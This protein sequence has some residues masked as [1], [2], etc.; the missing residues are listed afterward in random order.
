MKKKPT[1]VEIWKAIPGWEGF[2]EVSDLGRVRSIE[3]LARVNSVNP[4]RKRRMG[5]QVRKLTPGTNGYLFVVLT[6]LGRRERWGAHQ[7]VLAA[8]IGPR[9]TGLV[10]RHLDGNNINN[11]PRN[12]AWG[13]HKENMEDRKKHGRYPTGADHPMAKLTQQDVDHIRVS[14]KGLTELGRKFGVVSTHI[15]KI[16]RRE[17]W[18]DG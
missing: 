6:A 17:V 2:Y 16:R 7:L 12:L 1:K 8:F 15:W 3:R 4:E 13:T 11:V 9:P 18:I 14:A 10:S 5:G